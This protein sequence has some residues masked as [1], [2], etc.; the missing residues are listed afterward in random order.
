V[1]FAPG[2]RRGNECGSKGTGFL[3]DDA[4]YFG[5]LPADHVVL[6]AARGRLQATVLAGA[7]SGNVWVISITG[8]TASSPNVFRIR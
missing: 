3:S 5:A 8:L 7:T 4:V 6:D 2:A 1:A